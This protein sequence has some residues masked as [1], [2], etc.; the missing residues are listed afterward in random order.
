M[1]SAADLLLPV[2][3]VAAL[4]CGVLAGLFFVFSN[5]VMTALGR[6]P[7]NE[8]AAA[9]QAINA[10]I[11]NPAFLGL[12]VGTAV[13]CLVVAAA[14]LAGGHPFLL[15][16]A[17]LYL[18]GGLGVTAAANVPLNNRLE[19]LGPGPE[20]AACWGDYAR[21]WTRWNHVRTGACLAAAASLTLG[22]YRLGAGA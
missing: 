6:R 5:T 1:P 14:A 2:A 12:F 7:P 4:G 13:A 8:A 22:L 17:V 3:F 19:R 16:G 21:R 9:M 20:A 15:G 18:A 10:V 11:L